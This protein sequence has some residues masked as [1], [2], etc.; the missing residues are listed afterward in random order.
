MQYGKSYH[1]SEATAGLGEISE[2][3]SFRMKIWMENKA[4]IQ[5][6]N[7]QFYKVKQTE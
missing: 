2:E 7:R 1:N 5:K 4:D 3:E 6:H